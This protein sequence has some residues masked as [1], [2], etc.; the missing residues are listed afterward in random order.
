MKY[1]ALNR[2]LSNHKTIRQLE[3]LELDVQFQILFASKQVQRFAAYPKEVIPGKDI[4]LSFPEF[5]GLEDIFASILNGEQELFELDAIGRY[6]GNQG[7]LYFNIYI[8]KVETKNSDDIKLIVFLEDVTEKMVIKQQL[9]QRIYDRKL[10][11]SVLSRYKNYMEKVI[12]SMVDALVVTTP[13]GYIKKVN[14]ATIELFGYSE[15]ELLHKPISLIFEDKLLEQVIQ[16]GFLFKKYL[17]GLEVRCRKKNKEKL[18]MA[19]SC[20]VIPKRLSKREDIVYIGRDITLQK[21]RHQRSHTQYAITRILSEA[22][23]VKQAIPQILQAMC[24]CLGWDLGELWTANEYIAPTVVQ[25]SINSV[26]RCVETWSNR[27]VFAR[28][29]KAIAWK[30]TYT[31]GIGLPGR[32]WLSRSPM[33]ISDVVQDTE[34][35]RSQPAA[36]AGLH[37]VFGFPIWDDNEIFGVM[38]FFSRDVQAK[39]IDLLQMTASI[40]SQISQFI[41]RKLAEKALLESE[42]RYRDLFENA[43]E[44][45]H[46]VTPYGHFEYVNRAWLQT[47]GYTAA[48]IQQIN[49][50]DVIHSD[51]QAECRQLFYRVLSSEELEQV[52]IALISKDGQK[53]FVEGNLTCKFIG[54]KP[55]AIHGIFRNITQR[56]VAEK[57]LRYQQEQTE[58]LVLNILPE[59]IVKRLKEEPGTIAEHYTD[60]TV[61]F[62]DIVGFTKIA[63]QMSAIQLVKILNQIFSVFDH[64]TEEYGLEK[65]KTIGD[66]YM[67]VGGLPVRSPEH[68]QAIADMALDMQTAIAQFNAEN[69]QN[70]SIRIGIHTGSVVAGVIGIKKVTYDLWGDTVNIASRMESQGLAGKIQVTET[71]YERLQTEFVFE[72]RGEIEVKGKGVMTT[73]L[74][75]GR[76]SIL[77]G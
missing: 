46:S 69:N 13:S 23:S 73:Y 32:I 35:E 57:N 3:R 4:R 70:F 61:L 51:F 6:S 33:W 66:A 62:A 39:D 63:S 29:F 53:I 7:Y 59:A 68:T 56:I 20:S 41:K 14:R 47:L 12:T 8:L 21:R 55:V 31:P 52:T 44:L 24:E 74:L 54:N 64:L 40:G 9:S 10:L 60:V 1:Q 27:T 38:I 76:K 15:E 67:V 26:L 43:N 19:F 22:Q 72:K 50:F 11:A 30:T 34:F 5:I 37:S 77:F 48:E 28:E 49:L 2:I 71:T 45:I 16:K 58:R 75:I 65:I 18:W 36:E 17:P 25:N 42:E